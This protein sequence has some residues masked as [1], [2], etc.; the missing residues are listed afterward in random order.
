VEGTLLGYD[1]EQY[2]KRMQV[3]AREVVFE[4]VD[5]ALFQLP[6][7]FNPI[8]AIEMKKTMDGIVNDYLD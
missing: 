4:E 5:P 3:R 8:G 7:G 2:G 1:V 6:A